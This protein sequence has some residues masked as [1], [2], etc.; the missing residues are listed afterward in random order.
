MTRDWES[1]FRAW[2]RP[3]GDAEE[4]RAENAIRGIRDAVRASDKLSRRRIKVFVQGSYRNRV[5]VR[6]ESDVDVGIML[7]EHFLAQYPEGKGDVDFGNTGAG[8]K[9]SQFKDELEEALVARFGRAAV[10]RGN[11]AFNIRENTYHVEA[12]AAPFAEFRRYFDDG[13]YLA[14]VALIPD[15]GWRI[16]NY[17]ERLV[18]YWPVTPLHCENGNSKNDAT[19]R[20]YRGI[21][22]I[23][24]HLRNE[25]EERGH[26]SAKPVPGYLLECM[27]W[28]TPNSRFDGQTWDS[29]VQSVLAYIWSNTKADD[30]CQSWCEVDDIKYLCRP[31]QPWK[32]VEAHAFI[33]AAWDWRVP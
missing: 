23:L 25:M 11:K 2:A 12:D 31:Q 20:R 15:H 3:P 8:Y 21:V 6:Q 17:P 7:Y 1:T 16:V 19:S 14:G 30:S 26:A 13:S 4:G 27:V 29:R 28:N 24:K 9:F 33:N 18:E 22:R 32:R 5:N 10:R